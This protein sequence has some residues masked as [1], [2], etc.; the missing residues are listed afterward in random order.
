VSES[1]SSDQAFTVPC[2]MYAC[3]L[4]AFGAFRIPVTAKA[5]A[6]SDGHLAVYDPVANREWDFWQ[7]KFSGS[8]W[9]S[10]AGAAVSMAASGIA[11]AATGSGNAANFPLLGGLIRPE[12]I[13][14]GHIDHALVFGIGGVGPGAPVCPASHNAPTSSDA[15]ALREGARV[16]LDPSFDVSTLAGPAYLKVVAR[17]M[18]K[19][20]MYLRDTAGSLGVYG[21]NPL[22][23]GYNPWPA[24]LGT[25][26]GDS[27]PTLSGIPWSRFRVIAAPDYPNC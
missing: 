21:E 11:P 20:G 19:Y 23:R 27:Y 1:H 7:A 15:N 4:G 6:S 8:S 26:A 16:Q 5:D 2:T 24:V 18:Q 17:A 3:S 9:S 13:A 12:E 22:G 25:A 14:Q 10:S